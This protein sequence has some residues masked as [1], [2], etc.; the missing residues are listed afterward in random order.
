[1]RLTVSYNEIKSLRMCYKIE[2]GGLK[3][4]QEMRYKENPFKNSVIIHTV[5]GVRN[6]YASPNKSDT[7]TFAMVSRESGEDLGDIAFGRKIEVDKTHFLKLYADGVKMFL[8]LKSAGIKVFM[9]VYDVLMDDEQYQADSVDLVYEMLEDSVQ[10]QLS[11]ATFFRGINELKKV[12]FLA[13][14]IQTGKY[15]INA[16]YVFRGDRLTL[17]NTY[18]LANTKQIDKD[19]NNKGSENKNDE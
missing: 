8:G 14:T 15:W 18:V 12:N 17:V 4:Q 10:K 3:M 9:L 13:P 19:D 5:K 16:D 11:R 2:S 1:M 6:I 7:N